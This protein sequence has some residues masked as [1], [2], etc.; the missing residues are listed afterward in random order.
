MPYKSPGSKSFFELLDYMCIGCY[1]KT[2][3]GENGGEKALLFELRIRSADNSPAQAGLLRLLLVGAGISQ[4]NIVEASEN[5]A[6]YISVFTR[7]GRQAEALRD[8]INGMGLKRV[9]VSRRRLKDEDWKTKWKRDLKPFYITKDIK[10]LPPFRKRCTNKG[11]GSVISIDTNIAF[12]TGLHPTTRMV[13]GLMESRKGR[14]ASFFDIGTGSGILSI[15]AHIYGASTITAID[16][17][18]DAI[19][20]ARKNIENNNL[21]LF[22]LKTKGID[23]FTSKK[24]FD[25]IAANLFSELL[26]KS[27]RRIFTLLGDNGYLGIS[28]ILDSQLRDVTDSFETLRLRRVKISRVGQWR[29]VLYKKRK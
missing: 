26:I 22:S 8:R 28:G 21:P 29:A 17:D 18:R 27:K 20:T 24:K 2:I 14:F 5:S 7:S 13:A 23:D 4:N 10:V 16:S 6:M 3:K 11:R 9:S 25:F 19:K 1:Y 15:I 12:G